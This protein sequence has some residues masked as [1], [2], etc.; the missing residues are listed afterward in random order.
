MPS[1]RGSSTPIVVHQQG[2]DTGARASTPFEVIRRRWWVLLITAGTVCAAAAPFALG[3]PRLYRASATVLV[4]GAEPMANDSAPLPNTVD[5]RLQAIK[6]EAF[7]RAR[8]TELIDRFGLYGGRNGRTPLDA[9]LLRLQSDIAIQSTSTEVNGQSETIA[10]K[11]SY[12]GRTPTEAAAVTNALAAFFVDRN[13][14]LSAQQTSR[15]ADVLAAQAAQARKRLDDNAARLRMYA[16]A[17]SASMPQQVEANLGALQRLNEQLRLNAD[18]QMRLTER[19]QSLEG[20]MNGLG[21]RPPEDPV[22]PAAQLAKL[23]GT[24]AELLT[25]ET[26]KYP[27]VKALKDQI[28]ALERQVAHDSAAAGTP[29]PPVVS[30]A[31]ALNASLAETETE[32]RRLEA[33]SVT[34]RSS[35]ASYERRVDSAPSGMP[36]FQSLT[37]DYEATRDQ[38]DAI[39]KRLSDAQLAERAVSGGASGE[40]YRILDAAVPPGD[41]GG[42]N[43]WY[44]VAA[45]LATSLVLGIVVAFLS[46]RYD[47]SFHSVSELRAFTSVPVLTSIPPIH[48]P[49]DLPRRILRTTAATAVFVCALGGLGLLAFHAAHGS[50]GIARLLLRVA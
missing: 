1:S 17:N 11:L 7:S 3:L 32:R 4:E 8:L 30:P 35:I 28:A 41:A 43:P 9:L 22:T 40:R 36:E 2:A 23:Q 14:R 37:N 42:P 48:A 34:L 25:H 31:A 6:Q 13:D 12:V 5:A 18:E 27:D 29:T 44:L 46:D 20:Q 47:T 16:A 21:T 39:E 24:L 19:R 33:E 15:T 38:Y 26:D 45:I 49:G 50:L 10:F